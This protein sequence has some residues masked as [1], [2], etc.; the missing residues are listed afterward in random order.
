MSHQV[1]TAIIEKLGLNHDE[2][3]FRWREEM[4][5]YLENDTQV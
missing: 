4:L 3:V 1:T 5:G 2:E